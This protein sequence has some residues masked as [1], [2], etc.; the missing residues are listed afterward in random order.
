MLACLYIPHIPL[1]QSNYL[2]EFPQDHTHSP[3]LE[4][5]YVRLHGML[6]PHS[7]LHMCNHH[8]RSLLKKD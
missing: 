1:Q 2:R 6:G 8:F 7:I 4:H 3:A 5:R